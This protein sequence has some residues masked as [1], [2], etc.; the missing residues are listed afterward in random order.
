MGLHGYDNTWALLR[1]ALRAAQRAALRTTL[2]IK[3]RSNARWT[4]NCYC[5][6]VPLD[7]QTYNPGY[8][9]MEIEAPRP[10]CL[11]PRSNDPDYC[12]WGSDE[13]C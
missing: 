1:A 9:L 6:T 3:L 7:R 4:N 2:Q 10:W 5:A 11:Q 8:I 12:S 13:V